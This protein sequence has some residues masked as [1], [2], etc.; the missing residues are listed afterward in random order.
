MSKYRKGVLYVRRLKQSD[1]SDSFITSI[2]IAAKEL[3][4][5]KYGKGKPF[6]LVRHGFRHESVLEVG[7][8]RVEL[9]ALVWG[10]GGRSFKN[11]ARS[12][13]VKTNDQG[14]Q[15]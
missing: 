14:E 11:T 8:S 10:S 13:R 5:K 9:Q 2:Q 3:I 7:H 4:A 15:K 12:F 6:V 1:K